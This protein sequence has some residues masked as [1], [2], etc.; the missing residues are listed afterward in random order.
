M[1]RSLC[2]LC[3]AIRNICLQHNITAKKWGEGLQ[4]AMYVEEKVA[5][6]VTQHLDNDTKGHSM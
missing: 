5:R 1:H 2:P 3:C 4:P 6:K